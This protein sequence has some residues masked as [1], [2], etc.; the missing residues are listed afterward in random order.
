MIK[1]SSLPSCIAVISYQKIFIMNSSSLG[2]F[3]T[4][5]IVLVYALVSGLYIYTSDYFLQL[6]VSN[7]E[8]LS[9]IQTY[10]GLGFIL[11][12][13]VLLYVL[14]KK[15]LTSTVSYYEQLNM[16]KQL[17]EEQIKTTKEEYKALFNHSPLPM[18]IFDIDTFQFLLVNEAACLNYGYTKEEYLN[19]TLK[20]IRPKD[21]ILLMERL[22]AISL[23]NEH[24]T[25]PDKVRHQK[26]SGEIIYVK[27]KNTEIIFN[28]KKVRLASAVDVTMEV[29]MHDDLIETN[30]KLKTASEI[31]GLG[32]W[33]NNLINS[34]IQWSD[35]LYKIFEITPQTFKLNLDNIKAFFHP[36]YQLNFDVNFNSYFK[37]DKVK[38]R[39]QKI[40]TGSGNVKWILERL[41]LIRDKNRVPIKIQGIA[42]DITKRKLHEQEISE[43]NERFK[44]LSKATVEIIIDWDINNKKV[45]WGEGFKTILGYDINIMNKHLWAQNIHPNDRKRVLV[46]LQEALLDSKKENF[47]AEFRFLKANGEVAY[48]QHRGVFIRDENGK[49]VRAIGAMIDFTDTLEKMKKIELQNQILKDIAWTQSHIVRAP[50]ANLMGLIGLMKN[51]IKTGVSDKVLIGYISDSADRLDN[52]IHD[53]VNKTENIHPE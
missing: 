5:N 44:I 19:M 35:E 28:G 46:E 41:F 50:L 45:I 9:K 51:N 24:F 10:K 11:V 6:F 49:A 8:F 22:V 43:S 18:W 3:S 26:K 52:I 4:F 36:D 23:K 38:E 25:F 40:I 2:K 20:D 42:L 17:S 37:D 32:Y 31:A 29:E 13:S 15:N 12:T 21:D 39:E 27:I 30:L 53:I 47:N 7:I 48:M 14:V 34:E 1:N 33:S 16:V